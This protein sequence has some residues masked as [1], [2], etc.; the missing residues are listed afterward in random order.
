MDYSETV[1]NQISA[2]FEVIHKEHLKFKYV[3]AIPLSALKGDNIIELS[4]NTPW[5]EGPTLIEW[6]ETVENTTT[7][8]RPLRLPIQYVLRPNQIIEVM[9]AGLHLALLSLAIGLRYSHPGLIQSLKK[10]LRWTA[11]LS[12][13][14]EGA[15]IAVTLKDEVE[16]SRGNMIVEAGAPAALSDQFRVKYYLDV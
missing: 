13:A 6:L 12:H 1:F 15:S 4:N 11:R 8:N 10:L 14:E 5:Y 2:D 9:L 7:G 3:Q 16:A